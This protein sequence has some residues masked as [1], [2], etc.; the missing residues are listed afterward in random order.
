MEWG[1]LELIN[2]KWKSGTWTI[3]MLCVRAGTESKWISVALN[4]WKTR[5][6][7]FSAVSAV[8]SIFNLF[9]FIWLQI[10]LFWISFVCF[11][12][13][14]L[15]FV[16][17]ESGTQQF[18]SEFKWE[19]TCMHNWILSC[20]LCDN[21]LLLFVCRAFITQWINDNKI[22]ARRSN[23]WNLKLSNETNE[24]KFKNLQIVKKE[25]EERRPAQAKRTPTQRFFFS[26]LRF[27]VCKSVHFIH[28]NESKWKVFSSIFNEKREEF[29]A[30][31]TKTN[32]DEY[33]EQVN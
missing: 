26:S 3:P 32:F 24:V 27:R 19:D 10:Q 25:R 2:R 31:A 13:S 16:A 17:Y 12:Q 21:V 15:P 18:N 33:V 8:L 22:W 5:D 7:L 20:A 6:V 9:L 23:N 11:R 28:V 30:A 4:H 29:R 1:L 14:I